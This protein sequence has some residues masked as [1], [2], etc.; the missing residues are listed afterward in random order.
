MV[1]KE[2]IKK[3]LDYLSKEQLQEVED[4]IKYINFRSN[5]LLPEPDKKKIKKLYEI[6]ADEDKKIAEEGMSDYYNML[7]IE[8]K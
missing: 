4:F 2:K 1:V 8:D 6:F 3:N 5:I 7:K